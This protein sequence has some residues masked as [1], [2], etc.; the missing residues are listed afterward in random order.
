LELSRGSLKS[1]SR[2]LEYCI[3]HPPPTTAMQAWNKSLCEGVG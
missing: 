3:S 1:T 2:L